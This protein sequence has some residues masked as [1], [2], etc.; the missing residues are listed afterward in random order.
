MNWQ[1]V[2]FD[3]NHVRAFLATAEEGSLSAA[4]RVLAQTQPTL[5]RQVAALEE[6]LGV[7]LFERVGRSLSLTQSGLELLE[8][9]RAMGDAASRISLTASGQS[10]TIEGNVRLTASDA[11]SAYF[12]PP[13][14]KKLRQVAPGLTV[15]IVASNTVR[16]LQQ[17]EADIAIR[18][19]RPEQPDLIAK[20]V[21]ETTAHLYASTK[22]LDE[23]GRPS[24]ADD[25]KNVVFIGFETSDRLISGLNE[26]GLSLTNENF[27]LVSNSG[28][29]TWEMVKHGLG[30]GVMVREVAEMT[31]DTELVLPDLVPIPVPI[32]L[33]THREL[34]TSRRIRL[35]FDLLADAFRN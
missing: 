35:V 21:R 31:P 6:K 32:W 19:I 17:R 13:V 28:V 16:D 12:L 34:H 4:A 22:F 7:V 33:V 20:L 30:I 29:A 23:Q 15:E 9:V 3:W 14:L 5:G 27:K 1:A 26:L 11:M 25:L 18:H 10:Q 8:H 2:S 24:S